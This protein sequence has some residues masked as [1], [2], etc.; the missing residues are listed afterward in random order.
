MLTIYD[1]LVIGFYFVFLMSLG[2]VFKH[3]NKNSKDYF[4][5]GQRMCWW[6]LGGSLFISNFSCWTFTGAAGIA[7]KYGILVMY[8]YIMNVLGYIIGYLFFATRLRQM[9]LITAIDGVRRRY[10]RINEQFFNWLSILRAPLLG[11]VWLFG[12]AVILTT[13]FVDTA[14]D[15]KSKPAPAKIS[16]I[17]SLLEHNKPWE[18]IAAKKSGAARDAKLLPAIREDFS[19]SGNLSDRQWNSLLKLLVTFKAYMPDIEHQAKLNGF[20]EDIRDMDEQQRSAVVNR[21]W[22]IIITGCTVLIMAMLGGNW[23][24]V[25]SDFIQLLLLLS[26]TTVTAVLALVK[27]G[28]IGPFFKQ[29]PPG[30]FKIF[31]SLGEI[32]YD[33][34]FLLSMVLGTI[35]IRNN[36]MTAGK[37]IA[38]RDSRHARLSTLIPLIGYAVMPLIWF[39]PV[40]AAHTLVPGL[41]SEYRGVIGNPEE[42][43]YIATALKILPQGLLGLLVVGLFAATMSSMDTS[44]NKNAGFIVC[45]FY[46]DILRPQAS[47]RELYLAGQVATAFSGGCVILVALLLANFGNI[48]IFDSYLYFA[49]FF[50]TGSAVAFLLGMFVKQTPPWVA[51]STSLLSIFLSVML[52][53]VLRS[54]WMGTLLAPHI[55]GTFMQP[56]MGYIHS[57]PFFMTN[58]IVSPVCIAYFLLSRK[59]YRPERYPSY[60]ASVDKLFKDMNTPVDF[61]SEI[62]EERD[63]SSQQAVTLGTLALIYGGGMLLLVLIPNPLS[64][65]LAIL[66]CAAIMLGVGVLLVSAG[67]F[68][69]V[70]HAGKP[71]DDARNK[72]ESL[73]RTVCGQE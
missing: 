22:I 19:T 29:L 63:N 61:A 16:A 6:L 14:G 9:R 32:K 70:S 73:S 59:F 33:W 41:M 67:R 21:N 12:L 2:V 47:D 57:N 64:G 10:G 24:V 27:L 48:S 13:I 58:M 44:F 60:V 72:P 42:M 51:W 15:L 39:I 30:S 54:E 65:R 23:A 3:F 62:G 69:K 35:L 18:K 11:G 46:R 56:L 34:L 66:G 25:A 43:A 38:A 26:I 45:N 5:G 8:V 31:Y 50:G 7:Y 37:Y 20:S 55:A 71:I 36:I 1:Y 52:F 68:L 28:G 17:L 53:V 40:W 4:A 49:A